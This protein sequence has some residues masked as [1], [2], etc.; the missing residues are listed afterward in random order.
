[1]GANGDSRYRCSDDATEYRVA[2][3]GTGF[4]GADSGERGS[5]IDLFAGS[6]GLRSRRL[7]DGISSFPARYGFARVQSRDDGGAHHGDEGALSRRPVRAGRAPGQRLRPKLP[8]QPLPGRGRTHS[9]LLTGR[10]G[11]RIPPPPHDAG[12]HCTS[13]HRIRRRRAVDVQRHSPR[14]RCSQPGFGRRNAGS[15][16]LPRYA[17]RSVDGT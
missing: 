8:D 1:M 10:A 5:G 17:R 6:S 12:W 16:G 15:N 2:V 7:R 11:S 9:Q 13:A 4:H 14:G 3:A